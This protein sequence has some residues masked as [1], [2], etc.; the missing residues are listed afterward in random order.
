ML[1]TAQWLPHDS[2][3]MDKVQNDRDNADN[4]DNA[5][6]AGNAD[7]DTENPDDTELTD[8]VADGLTGVV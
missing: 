3:D 8:Q 4:A 7:N 1:L 2:A 5:D 6:I